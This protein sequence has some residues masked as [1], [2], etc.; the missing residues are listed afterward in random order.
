V[1]S[2]GFQP[3]WRMWPGRAHGWTFRPRQ[4]RREVHLPL[5]GRLHVAPESPC[6]RDRRG[7]RTGMPGGWTS[8]PAQPS[9]SGASC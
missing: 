9:A 2:L 5:G 7:S 1:G 4:G 6:D 3:G 8:R